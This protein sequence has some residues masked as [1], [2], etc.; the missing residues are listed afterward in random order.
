MVL[1]IVYE[2]GNPVLLGLLLLLFIEFGFYR[3]STVLLGLLTLLFYEFWF[4]RLNLILLVLLI[5]LFIIDV[6]DLH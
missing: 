6:P 2:C 5:L 4:D 3:G 1:K